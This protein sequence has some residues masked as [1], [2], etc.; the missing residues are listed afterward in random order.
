MY[1]LAV[2]V[3]FF[4]IAFTSFVTSSLLINSAQ[5]FGRLSNI[6]RAKDTCTGYRKILVVTQIDKYDNKYLCINSLERMDCL[7]VSGN[8]MTL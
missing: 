1:L 6:P 2:A 7:L 3:N 8:M 4:T 5:S